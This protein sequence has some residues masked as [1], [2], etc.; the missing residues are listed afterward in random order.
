[1]DTAFHTQRR[2]EFADT[3]AAGIAHFSVFFTFMEQVEHEFLRARGVSVVIEDA[4]G[5]LSWPR[6]SAHCDFISAVRFED[7]LDVELGISRLGSKSVTYKF[8]FTCGGRPVAT[9]HMT[10]VCCRFGADGTPH[11]VPI[12]Q[13]IAE[14]LVATPE[15]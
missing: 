9:G 14:K 6:V 15:P 12:P 7:V 3:D 11:S 1:M 2:V 5:M 4:E 10:S 8:S 13:W